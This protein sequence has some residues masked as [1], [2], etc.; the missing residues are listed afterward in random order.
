MPEPLRIQL[1]APSGWPAAESLARGVERLR[2]S[3]CQVAGEEAAKRRY[4]RFAG[5]DA[6]RAADINRLAD[7]DRVLPDIVM[8]VRGGYGV[9]RILQ[10]LDYAGLRRRL[11]GKPCVVV[12]HSDITALNLALLAQAELV[13]FAGP[14]LAY[15]FGAQTTSGFTLDQF[16]GTLRKSAHVARWQ[17]SPQQT[18]VNVMG[19][20]W[21]G[22]LAVLCSLLGTPYMPDIQR[23]ILFVED[24]FEPAYRIERL[25]SQLKLSGI[26]DRQR[27]LVLGDF[28][29][30]RADEYDPAYDMRAVVAY[31][32]SITD[33]PVVTHLPFGHC[34]NKLTLPVGARARLKVAADGNAELA[35]AGYPHLAPETAS[36]AQD[37]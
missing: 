19:T 1:I 15:D 25:L 27:A 22:N 14:M 20:L 10:H 26:L 29:G 13:T 5:T 12:G 21:G 7:P 11:T 34:R 28:S 35:F 17:G 36:A 16:W 2:Q 30:Y 33:V 31:V 8:A 9:H 18:P 23:G 37:A 4:L 32:R 6:E 24:V 3:G